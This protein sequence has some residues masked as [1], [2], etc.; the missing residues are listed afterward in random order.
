MGLYA[1]KLFCAKLRSWD[2]LSHHCHT[3]KWWISPRRWSIGLPCHRYRFPR[4][5]IPWLWNQRPWPSARAKMGSWWP[6]TFDLPKKKREKQKSIFIQLN[7]I[8]KK[9]I[10][11]QYQLPQSC[12]RPSLNPYPIP[13]PIQE[14]QNLHPL[15]VSAGNAQHWSHLL[16]SQASVDHEDGHREDVEE[17]PH[18]IFEDL[19]LQGLRKSWI[20]TH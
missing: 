14:A 17:R 12:S 19:E 4:L 15:N 7:P 20:M 16:P 9:I 18:G 5:W 3:E 2:K 11:I 13:I 8:Q 6:S 1:A 10:S